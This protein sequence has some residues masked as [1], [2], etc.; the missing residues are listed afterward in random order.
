M[1]IKVLSLTSVLL[2][3]ACSSSSVV[4]INSVPEGA[5][6]TS[7]GPSGTRILGKTPLQLDATNLPG[8]GRFS[9]LALNKDGH[10]D[11]YI[12]LG[13]DR[14]SENYDISVNLQP[15]GDDPK[16]TDA[17]SRQEKLAKLL[18]QGHALTAAK[19][20]QEADRVL[21][22]L[23]QEYPHVSAGYDLMGNLAYLQKDLKTALTHYERSLQINPENGETKQM[24]DR[25]KGMLQ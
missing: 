4:K 11:Q 16:V 17:R 1:F 9:S 24:V 12:F 10:K 20:Y 21:S 23:L 19:K 2:V 8:E 3:A 13:R 7:F 18:L 5:T 14:S 6:V 22:A 25:L 15:Q